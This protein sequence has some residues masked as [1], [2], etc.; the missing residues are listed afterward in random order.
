M[1]GNKQSVRPILDILRYFVGIKYVYRKRN[2]KNEFSRCSRQFTCKQDQNYRILYMVFHGRP[3]G[4]RI[5]RDFAMLPEVAEVWEGEL[6][7]CAVR[8]G[9]CS[10][11]RT[12]RADIDDLLHCTKQTCRAAGKR[13]GLQ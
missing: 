4:I 10:T 9:S 6:A 12:K 8:F 13:G 3:N 5:G 11:M 7:G 1:P 2:T